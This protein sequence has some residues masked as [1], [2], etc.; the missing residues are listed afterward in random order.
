MNRMNLIAASV[1]ASTG[2]SMSVDFSEV[3]VALESMNLASADLNTGLDTLEEI[4]TDAVALESYAELGASFQGGMNGQSAVVM[5]QGA[6]H[7]A[8]RWGV[9]IQS[10]GTE[11]FEDNPAMATQVA[12]EGIKDA[13]AALWEG[14]IDML[15]KIRAATKDAL[16]KYFNAGTKL[17]KA[18]EKLE[19]KVDDLG[20]IKDGKDKISG[21]FLKTMVING[22]PDAAGLVAAAEGLDKEVNASASAIAAAT[23]ATIDIAS[24]SPEEVAAAAKDMFDASLEYKSVFT[25]NKQAK[26]F[27]KLFG[28]DKAAGKYKVGAVLAFP[29]DCYAVFAI[30]DAG[31]EQ[32]KY[33]SGVNLD[34]ADKDIATL[35]NAGFSKWIAAGIKAAEQ[36]EATKKDWAKVEKAND[37]L[38]SE[39][40]KIGKKA[41]ATKDDEKEAAKGWKKI[42]RGM[43]NYAK[44]SQALERGI[45]DS[46]KNTAQGIYG[47][48]TASV[49]A[50]NK[51]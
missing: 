44:N 34:A 37:D 41:K 32:V 30:N 24:K 4:H 8:N 1:A 9:E 6:N 25:D 51:A 20:E 42:H 50:Y 11:S 18:F 13:A 47:Y 14:F 33:M 10:V 45:N 35:D 28:G 19:D 12:C 46:L 15:K 2:A 26:A 36:L 31:T 3:H 49:A 22:K 16:A 5:A 38:I 29:R 7:L 40:E 48:V 43:S 23:K 27:E 17:K 21:D 39:V